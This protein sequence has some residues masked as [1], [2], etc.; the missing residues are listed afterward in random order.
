MASIKDIKKRIASVKTTQQT[1]RAMKMVSAAKLRRAQE[2]IINQRPYAKQV[3]T[4]FRMVTARPDL[5]LSSPLIYREATRDAHGK[6]E[7][8]K[9]LLI[10]VTSDRGL[11][12]AFNSNVIKAAINWTRENEASYSQIEYAFVGRKAYDYFKNKKIKIASYLEETGGRVTYAK[13]KKFG[14]FMIDMYLSEKVD[15]VKI[16]YNEFCTFF[17]TSIIKSF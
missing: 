16:I 4:L 5:R 12:G 1:T 11:S 14:K 17:I 15:E 8:S 7:K 2:A 13:A 9:L 10:L 6:T 3:S